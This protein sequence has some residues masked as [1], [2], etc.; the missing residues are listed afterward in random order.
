[1]FGGHTCHKCVWFNIA[2]DDGSGC[3]KGILPYGYSAYYG[4]VCSECGPFFY[5]GWTILLFA[6][7]SAAGIVDVCEHHAGAAENVIFDRDGV[8]DADVVLHFDV[9]AD[10]D[11]ISD[12]DVLT[13]GTVFTDFCSRR[14][15]TPVPDASTGTQLG[16]RINYG[17][18]MDGYH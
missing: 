4:A 10:F 16:T 13:E 9:V 5:E 8:V 11:V 1:M 17:G 18:W 3:D 12:V 15:M 6:D 2:I 14:D 7:Y